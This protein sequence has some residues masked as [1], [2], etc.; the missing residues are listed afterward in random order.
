M[1]PSKP[2]HPCHLV[3]RREK[4]GMTPTNPVV[5]KTWANLGA[6]LMV[7]PLTGIVCSEQVVDEGECAW[8]HVHH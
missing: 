1:L 2:Q 3:C 7:V 8:H 5:T 6:L 4:H